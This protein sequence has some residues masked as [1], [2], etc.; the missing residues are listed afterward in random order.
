MRRTDVC[1]ALCAA[2]TALLLMGC[3]TETS[4]SDTAS[5]RAEALSS[6]ASANEVH[7]SLEG[8]QLATVEGGAE[9]VDA[10][11]LVVANTEMRLVGVRDFV[12]KLPSRDKW[13]AG[14]DGAY[15]RGN[16][17]ADLF[18]PSLHQALSALPSAAVDKELAVAFDRAIPYRIL[19]EI[20]FTAGQAEFAAV[21]LLVR[22]ADGKL[23]G[24]EHKLARPSR[25]APHQIQRDQMSFA[26]L[27][28]PEGFTVKTRDGLTKTG[29]DGPG[30]G[31]TVPAR[32]GK[33]DFAGLKQC[34]TKLKRSKPAFSES[35]RVTVAASPDTPFHV[36][37]ATVGTLMRS[38]DG[39][40]LFPRFALGMT[41]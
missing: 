37:A 35:L 26:V 28:A 12:V 34:A 32:G 6:S 39:R 38:G 27:V 9:V 8:V 40:D 16:S 18:I 33:Q 5:S 21:H 4:R 2:L 15:K 10:P 36:I 30:A 29:C 13:A 3:P 24:F 22:N 19:L 17:A 14:V 7:S 25:T 20:F 31:V 11:R 1:A 41:Q 23:R